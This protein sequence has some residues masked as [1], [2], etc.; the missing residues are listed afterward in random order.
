MS[1]FFDAF[2]QS[3]EM[4]NQVMGEPWQLVGA[5]GALQ[6]YSALSVSNLTMQEIA[7]P[8]GKYQDASA[9]ILLLTSVFTFSGVK[10]GSVVVAYGQRLRV[11]KIGAGGDNSTELVCGP[12]GVKMPK[13]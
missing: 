10:I 4:A 1:E 9:T 6:D 2:N 12:V 13:F 7:Q 11:Q 8:G 3:N 5:D